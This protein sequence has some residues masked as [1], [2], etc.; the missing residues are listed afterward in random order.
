MRRR[1]TVL[2]L[3]TAAV[4]AASVAASGT[5]TAAPGIS[6][7]TGLTA[8]AVSARE[9]LL[10]WSPA[11][12]AVAYR[13]LWG[14]V[15]TEMIA[16]DDTTQTTYSHP[17]LAPATS[18]VYAV[19]S[20]G[21][22]GALSAPS[23]VVSVTTPPEAPS[24]PQAEV[25]KADEVRLS[26]TPGTGAT[27]YAVTIVGDDGAETP[28][29]VLS[30]DDRGAIVRTEASTSYTFR[31]RSVAN[32]IASFGYATVSATTPP[33][34]P[35]VINL[36]GPSPLPAGDTV[37]TFQ[38]SGTQT[39]NPTSGTLDV[40][41]DGGPVS[42]VAVQSSIAS[43]PVSLEPGQ[44][45]VTA[46]YSGDGAFLPSD[47]YWVVPVAPPVPGFTGEVV[48]PSTDGY[49]VA[50]ADVTCD[51]RTDLL[52]GYSAALGGTPGPRIEVRPGH[53]DGSFAAP[54]TTATTA[55]PFSLA[56]GDLDGDGCAD[57]AAV[58]GA[59]LWTFQ[60]S[61]IGLGQATRVRNTGTV[62][63]VVLADLTGDGPLDAVVGGS[64]LSVF[65]GTGRGGFGRPTMIVA[66]QQGFGVGELDGD[67]RLDVV[68]VDQDQL[69]AWGQTAAGQFVERWTGR[70]EG[71]G[72]VVADVTGDGLAEVVT[73]GYLSG[74]IT[75][76]SGV[77]GG[78]IGGVPGVRWPPVMLATGDVDGDGVHDIVSLD[79]YS[80]GVGI[81]LTWAGQSTPQQY[82]WT[83]PWLNAVRSGCL[84]V[85]DVTQDG[86]ADVVAVDAGAGLVVLRQT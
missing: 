75:V 47:G 26:W 57:V 13:V 8:T 4:T 11:D 6:P 25:I 63:R 74:T 70:S 28:A 20:I 19:Q 14:V 45:G 22:R 61:A 1:N 38:I 48:D 15:P 82:V 85:T 66:S 77:Y 7:P 78:Q 58:L 73:G 33:R 76:L 2:V 55:V 39:L 18:Y 68:T 71:T 53:P 69:H 79:G 9:A 5:A 52:T 36:M 10:N 17:Y 80:G 41:I 59:E 40:S 43:L 3:L 29:T 86:R 34:E 49:A 16:L 84:L 83:N 31:I 42:Q 32:G 30:G 51:G 50:A 54:L 24:F 21:R 56:T 64:G 65:P 37:L 60:G 72:P 35:S 46:S 62:N 67:G 27:S 12:G 44:Y 81:S 23:P